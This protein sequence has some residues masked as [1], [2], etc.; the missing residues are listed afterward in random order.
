MSRSVR[1]RLA[2]SVA[3]AVVLYAV[4]VLLDFDPDPLRL[5]LLV[6][7]C[8]AGVALFSDTFGADEGAWSVES[9]RF[10]TPPGQDHRF[11]SFIRVIESHLT[12][13]VPDAALRDRLATV[14]ARKLEARHGLR[15]GEPGAD[16]LL[17]PELVAVLDGPP[18]ALGKNEIDRC[19]RRIEEL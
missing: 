4:L 15:L 18:R 9:V 13:D 2:S 7:V 6:L 3:V 17:G 11:A 5:T 14:A 8:L 19:V 12:A 16:E 1:R 10:A